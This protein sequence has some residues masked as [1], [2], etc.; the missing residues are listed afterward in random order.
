MSQTSFHHQVDN[1][2]AQGVPVAQAI[3]TVANAEAHQGAK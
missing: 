3:A 1:L 2:I